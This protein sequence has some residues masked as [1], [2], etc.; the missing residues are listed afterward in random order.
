MS[1]FMVARFGGKCLETGKNLHAGDEIYYDSNLKKA[2][3]NT[4]M[5]FAKEIEGQNEA[6]YVQAQEDAFFDN[7][8]IN[9]NI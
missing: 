6:N 3:C 1:K 8:C 2:F 7:F 5:R 4:S 9:N